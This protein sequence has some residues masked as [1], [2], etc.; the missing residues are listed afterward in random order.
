MKTF[1]AISAIFL[2]AVSFTFAQNNV[3]INDDGS[4]PDP[5]A[6]L[7]VQSNSKGLL[8]P[9]MTT[10]QRNGIANP[11][12]GLLVFDTNLNTFFFFSNGAW[13]SM[14]NGQWAENGDNIYYSQGNV[15]IKANDPKSDL[16]IAGRT[17]IATAG[18]GSNFRNIPAM[19]STDNDGFLFAPTTIGAN[20]DL[21]LYIEDDA[22]DAFS[23]YG[24]SC[25][26]GDCNDLNKSKMVATF[27]A[28]GNVG[29][30]RAPTTRLHV[31]TGDALDFGP[32]S[33][34]IAAFEKSGSGYISVNTPSTHEQGIL[35]GDE[36]STAAGAIIYNNTS[37]KKGLQFRVN[38]N[39]T[40]L[41]LDEE[42]NV[43]IGTNTPEGKFE[44]ITEGVEGEE[45]LDQESTANSGVD[46][47]WGSWQSFTAGETGKMTRI[48]ALK[49]ENDAL[50]GTLTIYEGEGTG[51]RILLRQSYKEVTGQGWKSFAL[52]NP[53]EM[54]KDAQY[55]N[56]LSKWRWLGNSGDPYAGGRAS[57]SADWDL[58]FKVYTAA[59]AQQ[60]TLAVSRG[61]VT[62]GGPAGMGATGYRLSV[63]GKVACEE[64]R[65]EV[66]GNWPDYVFQQDY[67]LMPLTEV[68]KAI[69]KNGHLPGIPAAAVVES[70]GLDMGDMQKRMME[71]IEELTLHL[72]QQSKDIEQ[73]KSENQALKQLIQK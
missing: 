66:A 47:Y 65:V 17:L 71:K 69:K 68:E 64:V 4:E 25:G 44:V 63:N 45:T 28:G 36:S 29:I 12:A 52:N 43:G 2:L 14:S 46:W 61:Q 49:A 13:R 10:A 34:S 40:K 38:G 73:L 50:S 35:F 16:H 57:G 54:T 24:N 56:H 67:P 32:N 18:N 5:S 39:Q 3:G 19:M 53:V 70:E 9:R 27:K 42:G 7:H 6:M 22:N 55:T 33:S 59:T 41:T 26:G 23:I 72:I 62:I 21:R 20:S 58:G 1:I 31:A 15:G 11:A 30:G 60:T 8:I 37:N 48:A 51:G